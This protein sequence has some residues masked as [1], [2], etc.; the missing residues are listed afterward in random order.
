MPPREGGRARGIEGGREGGRARGGGGERERTRERERERHRARH[1]TALHCTDLVGLLR[2]LP[3]PPASCR[4]L[5]QTSRPPRTFPASRPPASSSRL[6]PK[7][8]PPPTPAR[9]RVTFLEPAGLARQQ[10]MRVGDVLLRINGQRAVGHAEATQLLRS[11]RGGLRLEISRSQLPIAATTLQRYWRG[12]G[13]RRATAVRRGAA[14]RGA[15][16]APTWPPQEVVTA[17]QEMLS[18]AVDSATRH[19]ATEHVTSFRNARREATGYARSQVWR[20]GEEQA[21]SAQPCGRLPCPPTPTPPHPADLGVH[22]HT[23]HTAAGAR[24][25]ARARTRSAA[26]GVGAGGG[27]FGDG[28]AEGEGARGGEHG[29]A[30]AR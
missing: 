28:C 21:R 15:R 22:A 27:R 7:P 3:A 14:R 17:N 10:G 1:C 24:A 26:R 25:G 12:I 19:T 11:T 9:P 6:A 4:P 20:E 16:R 5:L 30:A 8:R 23:A 29:G 2:C 13:A 18:A